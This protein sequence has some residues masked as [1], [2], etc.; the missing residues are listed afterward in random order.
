MNANRIND[1]G[2][3]FPSTYEWRN[4]SDV[5]LPAPNGR[6]VPPEGMEIIHAAGLSLR[7]YFA[8][9]AMQAVIHMCAGDT[10]PPGESLESYFSQHAYA[11]ADAMLKARA[12]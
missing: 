6:P 2:P 10:L 7:D 12:K 4:D 1:G 8:A 5:I 11:I 9:R 3:A